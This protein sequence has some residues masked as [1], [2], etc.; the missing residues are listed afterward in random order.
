M[1]KTSSAYADEGTAARQL[2]ELVANY[3]LGNTPQTRYEDALKRLKT[4]QYF[5]PEMFEHAAGYAR[6]V[7]REATRHTSPLIALEVEGLDYSEWAPEGRGTADCVIV[8]DK[9]L[10]VIDFKYGKGYRVD[11]PGNSQMR[12]YALGAM[13]E[14]QDICDF[15]SVRMMIYQPRISGEPSVE[16]LTAPELLR[17]ANEYVRPRA[18][19]AF[20]DE[21]EFAPSEAVCKFCRAKEQCRARTEV[22]LKLFDES[23]DALL[24]TAEEAGEILKKAGD[25]KAWL[26][27]LERLVM[28][29]LFKGE[30]APGWKLVEGRSNRRIADEP[31]AVE[32]LLAAGVPE[33]DIYDRK[34]KT[35]TTLE[36]ALG[37]NR[38]AELLNGFVVKPQGKATL[39]P[40]TDKRPAFMPESL[41]IE[42]FEEEN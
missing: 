16:E 5:T 39:A 4:G 7:M 35:I 6:L 40:I 11:A 36:K 17:W 21:G 24:L 18:A 38:A 19:L 14:Y 13:T 10:V 22:N 32:L 8:G 42:A 15:D 30:A 33:T 34:M 1:P 2:A 41:I 37:K 9:T 20:A 25:V 28:T 23:P 26:S 29:A 3:Q 12:L 27:D 31:S